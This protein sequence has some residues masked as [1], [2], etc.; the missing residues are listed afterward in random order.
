METDKRWRPVLAAT[1]AMIWSAACAPSADE[2]DDL[3]GRSETVEE[4][5]E[6]PRILAQS[7]GT[8]RF[9]PIQCD[10]PN[11]LPEVQAAADRALQLLRTRRSDAAFTKWFGAKPSDP[12]VW[13]TYHTIV[14]NINTYA[15]ESLQLLGAAVRETD[16]RVVNIHCK[17]GRNSSVAHVTGQGAS[18]IYLND[19]FWRP[20][21]G[22]DSQAG[23]LVHEL[24]HLAGTPQQPEL[25]VPPGVDH[26]AYAEELARTQPVLAL[27]NADNHQFYY[28]GL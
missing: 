22:R 7:G 3:G 21:T 1:M 15:Q 8:A 5:D 27:S 17:G 2:A 10:N 26:K 12:A 24:T 23:I 28:E 16:A 13:S 20:T 9:T 25:N 4:G 19:F 14:A 18:T 11:R 6:G